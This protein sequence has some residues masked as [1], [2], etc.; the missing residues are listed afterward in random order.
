MHLFRLYIKYAND[1]HSNSAKEQQQ[2]TRVSRSVDTPTSVVQVFPAMWPAARYLAAPQQPPKP[3]HC[4]SPQWNAFVTSCLSP[5]FLPRLRDP[6]TASNFPW[7]RKTINPI[8]SKR[9]EKKNRSN[10]SR[11][12]WVLWQKR[13]RSNLEGRHIFPSQVIHLCLQNSFRDQSY[14]AFV[15]L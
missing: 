1:R 14:C 4:S 9:G 5:L 2:V 7:I 13:R 6:L 10:L 15:V 8:T 12:C 11:S 3:S